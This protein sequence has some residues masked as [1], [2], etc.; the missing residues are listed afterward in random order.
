MS[1]VHT[2]IGPPTAE[3]VL[4]LLHGYGADE[5][6]LGALVPYLDPEG[7]FHVVLP[8]GPVAAPPGFAWYE[9]SFG[10]PS[11]EPG[12]D[13]PLRPRLTE[14]VA[15]VDALLDE[16]CKEFGLSPIRSGN[17]YVF[18]P[19][20]EAPPPAPSPEG[21]QAPHAVAGM[22]QKVARLDRPATLADEFA[23]QTAVLELESFRAT[24]HVTLRWDP[25]HRRAQRL[26]K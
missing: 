13:A 1:L 2:V 18:G 3:R 21:I 26:Y 17:V 24:R 11:G 16:A 10:G 15:E 22:T 6:D 8:R 4:V 7:R 23:G 9:V 12:Q 25:R 20:L 19:G 5:R 14:A